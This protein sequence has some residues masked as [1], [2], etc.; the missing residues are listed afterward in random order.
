[1]PHSAMSTPVYSSSASTRT[2]ITA[3]VLAAG[4]LSP[5]QVG[6]VFLTGGSSDLPALRA[7]VARAL[8]GVPVA[9]G[10]MLGSVGAGLAL[11]AR[12]RFA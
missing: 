9:T 4:G 5:A 6:T 10:D 8:P 7:L 1:M 3:E 12:R 11:E 2:P